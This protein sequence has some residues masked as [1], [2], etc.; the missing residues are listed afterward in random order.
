MSFSRVGALA[1]ILFAMSGVFL[2]ATTVLDYIPLA[3]DGKPAPLASYRGKVLLI[4]NVASHSIF[5]PQYEGLE[6]LYEKYKD[7]GLVILAFPSNDFGQ[8]E[9]DGNDAIQQ[10]AA[11]K[12]KVTFPMFAKLSLAGE[13]ISPLYQFLTDKQANPST[14]GPIRWNFTKFLADREGKI[15]QRFEPDVAPDSPELAVAIEKALRGEKDKEK[16]KQGDRAS[17]AVGI[18]LVAIY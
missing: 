8:E 13:H 17:A 2:G 3:I 4:V 16:D 5:T 15:V 6:A 18:K 1:A 9:P 11:G 10:L 14:G 12:Y 7:Q